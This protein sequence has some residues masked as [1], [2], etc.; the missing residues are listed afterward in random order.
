[1]TKTVSA[2]SARSSIAAAGRAQNLFAGQ[3]GIR[4]Q[5]PILTARPTISGRIVLVSGIA[6]GKLDALF[7]SMF[8]RQF[9]WLCS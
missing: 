5:L 8:I 6:Q 9:G 3:M 7:F 4:K 1:L 2:G